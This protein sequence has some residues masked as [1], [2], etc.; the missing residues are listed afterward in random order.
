[1]DGLQQSA[2][3]GRRAQSA[4]GSETDLSLSEHASAP[5]VDRSSSL[6]AVTDPQCQPSLNGGVDYRYFVIALGTEVYLFFEVAEATAEATAVP[7]V[8][9][10]RHFP[11]VAMLLPSSASLPAAFLAFL[12]FLAFPL[13]SILPLQL[14]SSSSSSSSLSLSSP[15]IRI[16]GTMAGTSWCSHKHPRSSA[17]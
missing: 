7:S 5:P 16:P 9:S 1:M 4:P 6:G 14:F 12:T 11:W 2:S 10:L 3:A 17:R 8:P 15:S 13:V